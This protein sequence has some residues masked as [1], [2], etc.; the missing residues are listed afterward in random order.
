MQPII[1]P[2][3]A[4]DIYKQ[5]HLSCDTATI[6]LLPNQ[7]YLQPPI[8]SPIP[9]RQA[10]VSGRRTQSVAQKAIITAWLL[11]LAVTQSVTDHVGDIQCFTPSP[12]LLPPSSRD[13]SY[14]P[15][16]LP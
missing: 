13:T 3:D 14:S 2:S 9:P 7:S 11:H 15:P 5:Y 8:K 12:S 6:Y 1:V 4:G 10:P 16:R